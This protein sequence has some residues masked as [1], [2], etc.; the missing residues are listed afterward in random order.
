MNQ[1]ESAEAIVIQNGL[2]VPG[3]NSQFYLGL[4]LRR[5]SSIQSGVNLT[6]SNISFNLTFEA[7]RSEALVAVVALIYDAELHVGK[8][9]VYVSY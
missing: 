1:S 9:S 6:M 3:L 8:D 2:Y 4:D 7:N 5:N